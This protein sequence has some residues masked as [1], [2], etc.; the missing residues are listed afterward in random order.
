LNY[1]TEVSSS[2]DPEDAD[3]MAFV[4]VTSL[5]R[6]RDEVEEFLTCGLW[7][8]GEQFGFRVETKESPLSKVMVLMPMITTAIEDQESEA[9][10]VVHI[11]KVTTILQSIRPI[12]GFNTG[13]STAFSSWPE[14]SASP[15]PN[16]SRRNASMLRRG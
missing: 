12:R 9:N 1:L 13:G 11:E 16:P 3:F 5:I 8:L 10:F 2:C 4:N 15:N 7:P 14:F 6:G